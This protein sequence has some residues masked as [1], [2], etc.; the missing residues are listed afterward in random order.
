[1]FE[2]ST[3]LANCRIC[4]RELTD[5]KSVIQGIGPICLKALQELESEAPEYGN[6]VKTEKPNLIQVE[7]RFRKEL[8]D[9]LPIIQ[10]ISRVGLLHPI[11][12]TE[13]KR[14]VAGRRRLEAWKVLYGDKP[15]LV[16]IIPK[17]LRDAE[18]QE[19]TIRKDFTP[20]EV[21]SVSDYYTPQIQ[22]EHPVGR[23]SEK[24]GK[25]PQLKDGK[26][27]SGGGKFPP[28]LGKSRDAV[29]SIVGLSGKTV[30]K[31][32]A[33]RDA[34]KAEPDK[35]STLW[36]NVNS[37]K[38]SIDGAYKKLNQTRKHEEQVAAINNLPQTD[39]GPFSIIV[40]DPPW[41]YENR[42]E[43]VTHRGRSPYPSMTIEEIISKPPFCE[44]NCVV[45]LWTTNAF[46]HE[47]YHVL[48]AWELEPKTILTWKKDK[49]GVGDWLRGQT[50]HCIMAIKGKPVV[51]LT[52]QST[53][54]EG[55]VREHSRKPEEF[56][57][58]VE[59]LCLGSKFEMYQREQREGW[60]GSGIIEF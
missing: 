37:E 23:P 34:A 30:E 16:N 24:G 10:S 52:N 58:L 53:I 6:D 55:K 18:I 7:E 44:D 29:G 57:K 49:F 3:A 26:P 32:V 50:E 38:T 54:I 41:P 40:I 28:P 59:S 46:M 1:M 22:A 48:E 13:G 8:G 20:G 21:A 9:L 33:V 43:D 35:Y 4:N 14:L 45:W 17:Y 5:P 56:Y 19:N 51:T 39:E 42:V 60:A 27:P 25:F 15:I 31:I 11:V 47:A 12:I 36:K 2:D